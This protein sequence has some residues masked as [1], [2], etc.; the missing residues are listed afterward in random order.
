MVIQGRKEQQQVLT[1]HIDERKRKACYFA[2][3]IG[4]K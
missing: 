2:V 1:K 4:R 3:E